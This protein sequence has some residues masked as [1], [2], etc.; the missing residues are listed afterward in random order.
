MSKL[1]GV[2][3]GATIRDATEALRRQRFAHRVVAEVGEL[4]NDPAAWSSY[5]EEA[6]STS[7][8]DGLD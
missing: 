8:V 3:L 7:V 1:A 6:E 5:L 4:R 2:S